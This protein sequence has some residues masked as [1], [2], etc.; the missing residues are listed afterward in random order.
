M[1]EQGTSNYERDYS[2]CRT[3]PF[4]ELGDEVPSNQSANPTM[5]D[6]IGA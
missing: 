3:T 4:H 2:D 5:Y 6:V 1:I